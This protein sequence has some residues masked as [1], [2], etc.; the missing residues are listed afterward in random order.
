MDSRDRN[1]F[2]LLTN[3]ALNESD[4]DKF[5][6]YLMKRDPYIDSLLKNIPE[7]F[8]NMTDECLLRETLILD[9]LERERKETIEKMDSLSKN[10][11]A[12]RRYISH[13][14]FPPTMN[15]SKR[16]G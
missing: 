8:G 9:R 3:L 10:R 5:I 6:D 7:V 11:K 16:T 1:K 14:P 15:F 2:V 13:F 4:I 12:L